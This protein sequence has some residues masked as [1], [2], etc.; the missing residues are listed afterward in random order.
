MSTLKYLSIVI[1]I[2]TITFGCSNENSTESVKAGEEKLPK[3]EAA[4]FRKVNNSILEIS[5]FKKMSANSVSGDVIF[6]ADYLPKEYHLEILEIPVSRFKQDLEFPKDK[7]QQLEW[8]AAQQSENLQHSIRISKIGSM[9][10][11]QSNKQLCFKQTVRGKTF[12]FPLEKSYFLRFYQNGDSF[13]SIIAWTISDNE[14]SFEKIAQYMG[15][16]FRRKI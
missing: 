13:I 5:L 7:K 12:G 1:G 10:K 15:M 9:E 4:D 16:T 2:L 6:S 14:K 8:F 3:V 11:L